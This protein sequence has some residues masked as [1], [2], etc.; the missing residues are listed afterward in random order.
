[1]TNRQ[2]HKKPVFLQVGGFSC[3]DIEE[4]VK[5]L[6][7]RTLYRLRT[8]GHLERHLEGTISQLLQ[9]TNQEERDSLFQ[10]YLTLYHYADRMISDETLD[11]QCLV[12]YFNNIHSKEVRE[13]I[14]HYI[15]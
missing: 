1:M 10:S 5:V 14:T 8:M 6:S 4:M 13:I 15:W 3:T 9:A 2:I 7:E 11:Q 12:T